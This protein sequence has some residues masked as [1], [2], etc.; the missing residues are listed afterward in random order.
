MD[1]P[2]HKDNTLA[3]FLRLV[4]D[5]A[6]KQAVLKQNGK[7][8]PQEWQAIHAANALETGVQVHVLLRALGYDSE[9]S[10]MGILE[11]R[12]HLAGAYE[13]VVIN[14]KPF[15]PNKQEALAL[16]EATYK[17]ADR[18]AKLF[19]SRLPSELGKA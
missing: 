10:P 7:I 11:L 8:T 5:T 6:L 12:Y 2:Q 17:S 13:R 15:A 14:G 19:T 3:F 9:T 4:P 16:A 18:Q 1:I